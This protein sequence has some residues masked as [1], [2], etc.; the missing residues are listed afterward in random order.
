MSVIARTKEPTTSAMDAHASGRARPWSKSAPAGSARRLASA[1]R[2]V[3]PRIR[4][5]VSS[6]SPKR[7]MPIA[8]AAVATSETTSA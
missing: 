3:V 2:A 6:N 8:S 7:R 5:V 4:P 1:T